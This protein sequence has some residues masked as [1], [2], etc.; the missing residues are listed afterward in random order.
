MVA[1]ARAAHNMF[2]K[3]EVGAKTVLDIPFIMLV[4]QSK[5]EIYEII[6]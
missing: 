4:P 2:L 5:E 1:Y 3:G 6:L